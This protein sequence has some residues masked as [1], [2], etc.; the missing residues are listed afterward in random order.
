MSPRRRDIRLLAAGA[1]CFVVSMLMASA[2]VASGPAH[3]AGFVMGSLLAAGLLAL[4]AYVFRGRKGDWRSFTIWYGKALLVLSGM[5]F[6]GYLRTVPPRAPSLDDALTTRRITIDGYMRAQR[7]AAPLKFELDFVRVY[8]RALRDSAPGASFSNIALAGIAE[9]H[10]WLRGGLTYNAVLTDDGEDVP[11]RGTLVIYFHAKGLAVV[12]GLCSG[13]DDGCEDL[14]T[15]L[16]AAEATLRTRLHDETVEDVLPEP[17]L[18][19]TD[20]TDADPSNQS[21]IRT[22]VYDRG[23]ELNFTRLEADRAISSLTP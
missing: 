17:G 15:L 18:C 21:M 19:T 8:E 1:I 22:C 7:A 5:S 12:R 14:D 16:S 13:A 9:G 11:A 10:G 23:I 4:P 6:A 20:A 2:R 3:V